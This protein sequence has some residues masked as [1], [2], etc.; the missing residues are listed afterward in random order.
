[1]FVLGNRPA[2]QA[3]GLH[4]QYLFAGGPDDPPSSIYEK[5]LH[6]IASWEE[7]LEAL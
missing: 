2:H 7:T 3:T 5:E 1:M 6:G 4:I